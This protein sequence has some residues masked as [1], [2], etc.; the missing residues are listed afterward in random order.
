M[1]YNIGIGAKA[2]EIDY[3]LYVL[4]TTHPASASPPR[5]TY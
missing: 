5:T 2:S 4:M 1:L 3:V